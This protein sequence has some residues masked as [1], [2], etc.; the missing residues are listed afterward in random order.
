MKG[1]GE[2]EKKDGEILKR[3]EETAKKNEDAKKRDEDAKKRV[4]DAKK[5]VE[6]AKKKSSRRRGLKRRRL[7]SFLGIGI[8]VLLLALLACVMSRVIVL[9]WFKSMGV[10]ECGAFMLFG[11]TNGMWV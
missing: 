3:D 7:C 8:L 6:D 1:G 2:A 5:K 9:C 4:D 10:V 11:L